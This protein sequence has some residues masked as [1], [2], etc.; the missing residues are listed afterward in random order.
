MTESVVTAAPERTVREVADRERVTK[1]TVYNWIEKGAVT[2]RRTPG[3]AIRIVLDPPS[4][5][6]PAKADEKR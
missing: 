2:H 3:G 5:S 1:R 6:T 4:L